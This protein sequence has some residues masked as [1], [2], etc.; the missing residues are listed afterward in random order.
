MKDLENKSTWLVS[1]GVLA[2]I[3][4]SLCCVGPLI[5]TLIGIS[6]AA[7]LSKL[8]VLRVPMIF[9][10]VLLFGAA[11]YL[12]FRKR[13]SC[14]PSS[15]CANPKKYKRMVVAYWLGLIIAIFAITSINW[16]MWFF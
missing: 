9:V 8:E 10:V 14:E 6:G 12:L 16:I 11:G 15:I 4:A 5:L 3:T 1:G 2:A 13:E 7:V